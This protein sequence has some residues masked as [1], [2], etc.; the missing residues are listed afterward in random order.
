MI[1]EYEIEYIKYHFPF[2]EFV[3]VFFQP[4]LKDDYEA[5]RKR[6]CDWFGFTSVLE[7]SDI[8]RD[9]Q[10]EIDLNIFSKN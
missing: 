7:Y 1:T 9:K 5:Q 2:D 6:I 8:G 3:G 10:F 4:E